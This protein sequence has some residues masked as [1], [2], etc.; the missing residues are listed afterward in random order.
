MLKRIMQIENHLGLTPSEDGSLPSADI[1]EHQIKVL[2]ED[3]QRERLDRRKQYERAEHLQKLLDVVKRECNVL[4]RKCSSLENT[5]RALSSQLYG[6]DR[7]RY[8]CDTPQSSEDEGIDGCREKSIQIAPN[9]P[10]ITARKGSLLERRM[11]AQKIGPDE[12]S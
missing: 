1:Y 6:E 5:N 12:V 11:R 8:E 9:F 3:F 7:P 2:T 10:K 4:G